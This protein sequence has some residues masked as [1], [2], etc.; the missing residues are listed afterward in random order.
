MNLVVTASWN[1]ISFQRKI[2]GKERR[3][4]SCMIYAF[5]LQPSETYALERRMSRMPK[6][7]IFQIFNIAKG[8]FIINHGRKPGVELIFGTRK[9]KRN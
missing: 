1:G 4:S 3:Y 9:Q 7:G 6:Y 2:Q 8:I 5:G